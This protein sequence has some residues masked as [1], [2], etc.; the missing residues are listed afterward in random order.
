MEIPLT[1]KLKMIYNP[2]TGG[3][4]IVEDSGGDLDA[5]TA[6]VLAE[7]GLVVDGD[8]E[9]EYS[10]VRESIF[11]DSTMGHA[12]L[13]LTTACNFRCVYCF[14]E[15]ERPR[16]MD[17]FTAEATAC[18]LVNRVKER[19]LEG[20]RLVFYGGEP[21]MNLRALRIIARYCRHG[22]NGRF[23]AGVITNGYYLTPEV[24]RELWDLGVQW[25][26]VTIDGVPPFHEKMRP[27]RHGRPTFER[28]FSN[29]VKAGEKL[30]VILA[31]NY[32]AE[33]VEGVYRLVDYVAARGGQQFIDKFFARPVFGKLLCDSGADI[34]SYAHSDIEELFRVNMHA[35]KRG[36][37]IKDFFHLG[38]CN[39]YDASSLA[40]D[41]VGNVYPCEGLVHFPEFKAGNVSR[42]VDETALV[43]VK[44]V[45]RFRPCRRCPYLP[46]CGGGCAVSALVARGS[47]EKVMCEKTFFERAG[48]RFLKE[49]ALSEITQ[50]KE[51]AI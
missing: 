37:P 12:T 16:Y 22:L 50:Q 5:D 40:V 44:K 39:F 1:E 10:R 24:I 30:R 4:V 28:L 18:F 33:T 19:G 26:K 41:P 21:L 27:A 43:D 42:S 23:E 32:T 15:G 8:E 36:F 14:Q 9:A 29:M 20:L 47:H 45:E 25:V 3:E 35:A 48:V 17:D 7:A 13:L 11:A 38:P 31:A 6:E 51:V 34:Y 49:R 46:A 2:F